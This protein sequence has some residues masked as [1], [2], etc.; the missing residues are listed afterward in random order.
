M[1]SPQD[2]NLSLPVGW[3]VWRQ[4]VEPG[5]TPPARM[6]AAAKDFNE[7]RTVGRQRAEPLATNGQ[8]RDRLWAG[9]HD[10]RQFIG[11]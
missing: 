10:R 5:G 6:R 4:P 1:I 7:G 3:H 11:H 9:S 2:S 8:F